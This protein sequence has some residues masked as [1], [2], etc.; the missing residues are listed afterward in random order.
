MVDMVIIYRQ[1]AFEF[2]FMPNLDGS[3]MFT[4]KAN[5]MM[6]KFKSDSRAVRYTASL[7]VSD[8]GVEGSDM[9]YAVGLGY[10][11][12]NHFSGA[13]R[14]STYW[15]YGAGVGYFDAGTETDDAGNETDLNGFTIG[16]N[17]FIGAD[18]YIIQKVYV[19]LELNYGLG[20]Y[21]GDDITSWG[22]DGGVT[23]MMRV[24]FR[25]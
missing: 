15:G 6:R 11:I 12:E 16:A 2:N 18:Y 9:T 24:G 4:Y 1:H 3:T 13:E 5:V 8:S 20:V 17:A 21:S 22:L 14:L 19:G 7:N 23:G 10:G 25:L